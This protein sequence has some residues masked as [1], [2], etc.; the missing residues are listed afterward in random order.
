MIKPTYFIVQ[1]FTAQGW[2]DTRIRRL[3]HCSWKTLQRIKRDIANESLAAC[4]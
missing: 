4:D 2:T 1:Y 3:L